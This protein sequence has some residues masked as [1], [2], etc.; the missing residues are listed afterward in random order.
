MVLQVTARVGLAVGLMVGAWAGLEGRA[1]AQ[2]VFVTSPSGGG[3]PTMVAG[4]RLGPGPMARPDAGPP[5]T[6]EE[7]KAY[8]EL[9]GLTSEQLEDATAM[10]EAMQA[11][12]AQ[13][14]GDRQSAMEAMRKE[15]EQS[16][17]MQVLLRDAPAI[18]QTFRDKRSALER[19]FFDD[20][21]LTLTP[22]QDEQWRAMERLRRRERTLA[23]GMLSGESVDL[24]KVV[25]E[26]ELPESVRTDVR[27]L[28]AGY[29]ADLDRALIERN[30]FRDRHQ[31]MIQIGGGPPDLGKMQEL[32]AQS[33]EASAKVRDVNRRHA[34]LIRGVL[35]D[36]AA[37]DFDARMNALAMP[38][39]YGPSRVT[40]LMDAAGGLDDLTAEQRQALADLR[41]AY[42]REVASANDAWAKAIEADEMN[43]SGGSF[44][45]GGGS[46]RIATNDGSGNPTE[47]DR[48][49]AAGARR[50]L[51]ARFRERAESILTPEQREKSA[52]RVGEQEA[53]EEAP[54][55]DAMVVE[56][57]RSSDGVNE[58]QEAV[59]VRMVRPVPPG[60]SPPAP[61]G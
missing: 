23:P 14:Q 18:M 28:L 32:T 4:P 39:V 13:V 19:G 53:Q 46:I 11:E 48:A 44:F 33:R 59:N 3:S 41:E 15:Y 34:R 29:E 60:G 52:L 8:S 37:A 47:S 25:R 51:D 40:R 43:P 30:Q 9:L 12:F 36:A 16:K 45:F 55:G 26:M 1:A 20:L 21:R 5:V 49:R 31:E 35:P 24:V 50:D 58:P 7:L 17:D 42:R 22:E 38:D 6:S 54:V 61:G 56:V 10:L 2:A 27:E 57:H